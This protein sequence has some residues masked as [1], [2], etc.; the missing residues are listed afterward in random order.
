MPHKCLFCYKPLK[1]GQKDFHPSCSKRIFGTTR[2]PELPYTHQQ[3]GEMAKEVIRSQTT[4]TGVQPKLSL[5]LSPGGQNL[6]RRFTIVGLWGRY[7][8]KTQSRLY[9]MLPELED[10]TMHMAEAAKISVVPHSLIRFAD[11]ETAYITRRIDRLEDGTKLPMEDMCQ[12]TGRL[13][14]YKYSGSHEQVAKAILRH[15]AAPMLDLADYWMQV[16]FAFLTGN[17]DM[18]LKNY[19]LFSP[20]GGEVAMR[21]T[22]AYDLLPTA[23]VMPEDTEELALTLCGKK[24][25]LR[26]SHFESA[27][28]SSGLAGTTIANVFKRLSSS[29]PTWCQ[30][31]SSS[32]LPPELQQAYIDLVA[33]RLKVLEE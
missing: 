20:K 7:I 29:F 31:I 11:G 18:H 15:S 24:R 2:P 9:P 6:P 28:A 25:K 1:E 12:I 22:P 3:I 30:I 5:D 4:L 23:I 21:L 14:E 32:F 19:S 27:M 26:R 17:A 10:A 33:S 16:V 8:L 13:T